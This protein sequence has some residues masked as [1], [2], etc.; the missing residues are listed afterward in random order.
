MRVKCLAQEHNT[1][2]AVMARTGHKCI[3]HEVTAIQGYTALY[4]LD[5]HGRKEFAKT[6]VNSHHKIVVQHPLRVRKI[7]RIRTASV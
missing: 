6:A 3:N 7:A 4:S 1:V 2:S 5:V